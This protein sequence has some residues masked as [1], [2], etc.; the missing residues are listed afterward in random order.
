M[1]TEPDER[2]IVA[3]M[4]G[5][6][7]AI[8]AEAARRI[9]ARQSFD[10]IDINC[11]C[12]VRRIMSKGCGAALMAE[13]ALIERLVRAVAE[14][15]SLPVTVK[16]RIGLSPGKKN[17]M[18]VAHAVEAGGARA[19]IVHAR[20][21]SN[22]HSGPADWATLAAV[23]S[24]M[25][26]PVIG[27]GGVNKAEDAARMLNETGVDGVMVGRGAWG[28]P[29]IFADILRVL[30]GEAP[31]PERTVP[32]LR[33]AIEEHFALQLALKHREMAFRRRGDLGPDEAAAMTFRSHV[34]RYLSGTRGAAAARRRLNDL[35]SI[36]VLKEVLDDALGGGP[37]E[38][39]A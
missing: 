39:G 19:L 6:D 34:L 35:R 27:N 30:R 5:R 31:R 14:A 2:P 13:P 11:G 37:Q 12:P 33:A 1:D 24:A 32:E 4:Y 7:P 3:H 22:G 38:T 21:A 36:E 25:G 9:A 8:M 16:T 26:I 23:K 17:I 15:V 20:F 29:W 28:R 10:A 18:D